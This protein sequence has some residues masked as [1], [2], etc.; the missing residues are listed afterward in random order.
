M[1]DAVADAEIVQCAVESLGL[2]RWNLSLTNSAG[3]RFFKMD[4]VEHT[5]G[6]SPPVNFPVIGTMEQAGETNLA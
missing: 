1:S 2:D 3:D 4:G 6:L 5:H